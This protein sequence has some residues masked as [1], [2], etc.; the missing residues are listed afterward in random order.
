[1]NTYIEVVLAIPYDAFE[2]QQT[3]AILYPLNVR[4]ALSLIPM[5]FNGQRV[6]NVYEYKTLGVFYTRFDDV[7][8]PHGDISTMS[9]TLRMGCVKGSRSALFRSTHC[10]TIAYVLGNETRETS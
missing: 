1:M 6:N 7:A 3:C 8:V 4:T 2:V 10:C 5:P 9:I